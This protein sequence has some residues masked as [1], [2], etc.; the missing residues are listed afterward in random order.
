MRL[1]CQIQKEELV[2]SDFM[3]GMMILM[4]LVGGSRDGDVF[5]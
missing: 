5:W 3:H 1:V 2:I 4:T